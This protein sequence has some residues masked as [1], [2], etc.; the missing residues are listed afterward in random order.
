MGRYLDVLDLTREAARFASGRAPYLNN[1]ADP[2]PASADYDCS[3]PDQFDFYY[4]TAC[5]FSPPS[6]AV[7]EAASDP[8]CNGFNP[9]IAFNP[10]TDDVVISVFTIEGQVVQQ[11]WPDPN[12]YWVLSNHDADT[13]NNDNFKRDCQGNPVR[14][15]PYYTTTFVQDFL[16]AS[17]ST[18]PKKGYVAVEFYYCY[19]QVLNLPILTDIIPNPI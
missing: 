6:N 16:D 18:T 13:V 1:S 7:C 3:T 17:S 10:A 8:F 15:D 9:F 12:G 4:D 2:R 5:I 11:R 19:E 14:T